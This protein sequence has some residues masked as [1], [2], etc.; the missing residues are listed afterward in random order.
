LVLNP[1][2]ATAY[3]WYGNANLLAYGHFDESIDAM[4]RARDLDPLSLIINAD[5]GT[6]YCY[7]LR[8]DEAIDQ[9]NKTLEMDQDFYYAHVYLGRTYLLKGDFEKALDELQRAAVLSEDPRIPML[10]SRVYSK[11]GQKAKALQMLDELKQMSKRRYVSNF[12]FALIYTGLGDYDNAFASLG[13]CL[14]KHDGNLVYLKA[15]PL[16]IDLRTDPRYGELL[17]KIGL[18]K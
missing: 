12:D 2:Y 14:A 17:A 15:D 8:L 7:A 10:R 4:K 18:D 6:S 1:N 5:L 3:H 9:F 13:K 16:L 11:T